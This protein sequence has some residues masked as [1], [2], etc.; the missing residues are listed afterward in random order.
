MN[1]T[2]TGDAELLNMLNKKIA[3]MTNVQLQAQIDE[4]LAVIDKGLLKGE[5][6]AT[7][8]KSASVLAYILLRRQGRIST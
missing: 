4:C 2:K 6:L 3:S 7:T 5:I 8:K 1:L